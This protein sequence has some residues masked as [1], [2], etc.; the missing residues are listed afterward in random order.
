VDRPHR[1]IAEDFGHWEIAPFGGSSKRKSKALISEL[2][3]LS[4][5]AGSSGTTKHMT[6]QFRSI[7]QSPETP[8]NPK[9]SLL[10]FK[11]SVD[12]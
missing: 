5:T 8:A 7:R 6:L 1:A 10:Q 12:F 11:Q 3:E 9:S 2:P 4:E